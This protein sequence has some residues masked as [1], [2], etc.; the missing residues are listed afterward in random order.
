MLSRKIESKWQLLLH[1]LWLFYRSWLLSFNLN[2]QIHTSRSLFLNIWNRHIAAFTQHK[3]AF[4]IHF[5]MYWHGL[6]LIRTSIVS[7]IR[8]ILQ[9]LS[10]ALMACQIDFSFPYH[11]V[12][13]TLWITTVLADMLMDLLLARYHLPVS[14]LQQVAPWTIGQ[15][16][17]PTFGSYFTQKSE[18]S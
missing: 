13:Y 9:V 12:V 18:Y 14:F 11:S 17:H 3:I 4:P 2:I 15:M 16:D 1:H 8:S 6:T 7:L 5:F 10:I